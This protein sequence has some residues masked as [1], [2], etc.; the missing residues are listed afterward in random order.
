MYYFTPRF[1]SLLKNTIVKTD[2]TDINCTANI[3]KCLNFQDLVYVHLKVTN[4]V[5]WLLIQQK[6]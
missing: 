2:N 1:F 4:A 6:Y 3:K 5:Q